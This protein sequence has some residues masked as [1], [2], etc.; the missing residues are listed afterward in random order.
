MSFVV[1]RQLG[2]ARRDILLEHASR[3]FNYSSDVLNKA[4]S[5]LATHLELLRSITY[6]ARQADL[7]L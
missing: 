1:L 6:K 7:R 2:P 5:L 3:T 4:Q